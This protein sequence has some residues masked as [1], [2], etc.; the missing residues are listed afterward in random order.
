MAGQT[1]TEAIGLTLERAGQSKGGKVRLSRLHREV[2]ERVAS[3]PLLKSGRRG[4]RI[5][6]DP[7]GSERG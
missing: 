5:A 3:E 4:D 1:I 7:F 2:Q 6:R